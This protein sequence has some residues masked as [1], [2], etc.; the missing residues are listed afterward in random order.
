MKF[1]Q[2][3][4]C[5]SVAFVLLSAGCEK[6][7]AD[8]PVKMSDIKIVVEPAVA[9]Q[10]DVQLK[11]SY[12]GQIVPVSQVN[13]VPRIRGYLEA[14]KY[15]KRLIRVVSHRRVSNPNGRWFRRFG[16]WSVIRL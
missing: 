8:A 6:P 10:Q 13:I 9:T 14:V 3:F 12:T 1:R 4:I 7:A 2:A 15:F 5:L 11:V 16:S